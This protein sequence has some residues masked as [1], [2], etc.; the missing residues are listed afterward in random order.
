MRVE[1][2][3]VVQAARRVAARGVGARGVAARG[4]GT[5]GKAPAFSSAWRVSGHAQQREEVSVR[6][7]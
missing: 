4:V 3:R 5:R 2:A 7:S 6:G 1:A